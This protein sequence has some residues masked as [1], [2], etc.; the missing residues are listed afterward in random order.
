ML[1]K[2]STVRVRLIEYSELCP[3]LSGGKL[4]G[5]GL[6]MC[7][8]SHNLVL[9]GSDTL[10]S[11]NLKFYIGEIS[12][13]IGIYNRTDSAIVFFPDNQGRTYIVVNG[14][15]TLELSIQESFPIEIAP[16]DSQ[17]LRY[18][19]KRH[20]PFFRIYQSIIRGMPYIGYYLI[21]HSVF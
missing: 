12:G 8:S 3:Y 1:I 7:L 21:Q 17:T 13:E 20:K 9:S 11:D 6:F 10:N 14:T 19:S 16:Y 2:D 15:D 18:V 5:K 4:N